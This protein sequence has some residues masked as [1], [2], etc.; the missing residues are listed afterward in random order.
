MLPMLTTIVMMV[1]M[2]VMVMNGFRTTGENK[3]GI[4]CL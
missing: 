3:P 4:N 1:I 2:T